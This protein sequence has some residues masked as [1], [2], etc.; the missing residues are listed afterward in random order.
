MEGGGFE[1][2]PEV[3]DL[4]QYWFSTKTIAA[5][6]NE[7]ST[8]TTAVAGHK[9]LLALV[10]CPSVYFSL[11]PELR[12]V[13]VVLEIDRKWEKDPGFVYYDFNHPLALPEKLL[14]AATFVLIDPPFITREVWT[15]YAATARALLAPGGRCLC[16]SILENAPLLDELLGARAVRFRPSI[17]NLVYQYSLY[18][19]YASD[20]LGVANVEVDPDDDVPMPTYAAAAPEPAAA[21]PAT[22]DVHEEATL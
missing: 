7:A 10:S 3:A 6:V 16:A 12:A 15:Q 8:A 13:S 1:F 18:A 2:A 19:T 20:A 9:P 21:P 17:P 14:G 4:N 11:S 22:P 5:L